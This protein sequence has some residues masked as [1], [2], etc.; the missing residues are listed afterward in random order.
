[1]VGK[2]SRR[3]SQS[4]LRATRWLASAGLRVSRAAFR[5]LVRDFAAR[6][7]ISVWRHNLKS[8]SYSDTSQIDLFDFEAVVAAGNGK[9]SELYLGNCYYGIGGTLRGFSS[10]LLPIR[11]AIEHGVYFGS[12]VSDEETVHSGLPA[13]ITFS[14]VRR[15]HISA[16]TSKHSFA[17]GPYIAYANSLLDTEDI[18]R[19]RIELGR[20]LVVFPS[21]SISGIQSIFDIGHLI[22]SILCFKDRHHFESVVVCLYWSDVLQGRAHHYLKS[23]FKVVSAG[24]I[25]DPLFLRRL[26]SILLLA[27]YSYSNSVGTHVGYSVFLGV[28]HTI[29]LQDVS[30]SATGDSRGLSDSSEESTSRFAETSHVARLFR[31]YSTEISQQ[32]YDICVKYFGFDCVRSPEQLHAVLQ[33]CAVL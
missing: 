25:D 23:G 29:E 16:R 22:D 31:V 5:M 10:Y 17:I 1:M 11:A 21:H 2:F 3:L 14:E 6:K 33:D 7:R 24:H 8:E 4:R 27:D 15:Y 19:I 30:H 13:I 32:Q 20:T 18:A 12:H 9:C 26:R 28:P